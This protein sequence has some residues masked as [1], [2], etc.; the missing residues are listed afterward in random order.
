MMQSI[1][2]IQT[3]EKE[4]H[5]KCEVTVILKSMTEWYPE[6]LVTLQLRYWRAVHGEFMTHRVFSR[7]A[8]SSRAIPIGRMV[9]MTLE[10]TAGPEHWGKNQSGMQAGDNCDSRVTI[11]K[12]L[13]KAFM[14]WKIDN[15]DIQEDTALL[16]MTTTRELA[17]RFSAYLMAEMSMAY[18][19][20]G[21][22]KQI[23]NRLTEPFQYI[24]VVLTSS[25]WENFLALRDHEKAEPHIRD[26][27]QLV[28]QKIDEA[29]A[30]HLK[31][32]EWHMPYILPD[33]NGLT[34][35]NRLALSSARC[36]SVSYKTVDGL[37]MTQNRALDLYAKLVSDDPIHASPM[38]HQASVGSS[39]DSTREPTMQGNLGLP[40]RQHR[41]F[42]EQDLPTE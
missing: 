7:N 6:P 39:M 37:P 26:L 38:E 33:E 30:Q 11:P 21:Y 23:A 35:Q 40:W 12:R 18:S 14:A 24:N 20:A 10:D 2:Q 8:S 13:H 28:R 19:D 32:G 42:L 3:E 34:L 27:A 31:Y 5:M 22:H 4:K 9:A 1:A 17:W 29:P 25:K 41:K 16:N 15:F 36:A